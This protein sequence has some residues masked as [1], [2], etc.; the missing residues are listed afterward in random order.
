MTLFRR[1]T[2][3]AQAPAATADSAVDGLYVGAK[4]SLRPVHDPVMA[5]ITE[6]GPFEIAPKRPT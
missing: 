3:A 1:S 5:A 4:A 6:F 2:G